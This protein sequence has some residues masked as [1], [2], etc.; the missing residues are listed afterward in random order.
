MTRR[1]Q[2]TPVE[3]TGDVVI[4]APRGLSSLLARRLGEHAHGF[5]CTA[6][7]D[8]RRG[9]TADARDLYELLLLGLQSGDRVTV[10][11][12]G[13]DA[14]TAFDTVADLLETEGGAP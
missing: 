1:H 7:L 9:A 6:T 4:R 3:A 10:R 12:V 2:T 11:C 14:R 8:N 13:P 5:R